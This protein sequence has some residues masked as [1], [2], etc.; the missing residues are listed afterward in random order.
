[1]PK[2]N[3]NRI[4]CFSGPNLIVLIIGSVLALVLVVMV[5]LGALATVNLSPVPYDL[6]AATTPVYRFA[7]YGALMFMTVSENLIAP[8]IA[9]ENAGNYGLGRWWEAL[10]NWVIMTGLVVIVA[11]RL[12]FQVMHKAAWMP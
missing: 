1:M 11:Y 2:V 3:V 4:A 5:Y 6:F 9:A 10:F 8:S 12:P 7:F